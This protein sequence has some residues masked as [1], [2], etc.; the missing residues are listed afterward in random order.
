MNPIQNLFV[1]Y[2]CMSKHVTWMAGIL[3]MTS[4]TKKHKQS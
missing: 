2:V 3:L 1:L 4:M